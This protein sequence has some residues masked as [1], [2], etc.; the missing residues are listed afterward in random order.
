[1]R[2]ALPLALVALA[3]PAAAAPCEVELVRV[4][5]SARPIIEEWVAAE[6]SC[7]TRLEVRVIETEGGLYVVAT[8]AAGRIRERL[9]SDATT[10]AVLIASWAADAGAP[11]PAPPPARP[12]AAPTG[13]EPIT[14]QEPTISS[15]L[16]V[17]TRTSGR[18]AQTLALGVIM[19][20]HAGTGVRVEMDLYRLWRA[21]KATFQWRVAGVMLGVTA[22]GFWVDAEHV[23]GTDSRVFAL[24]TLHARRERTE[25]RLSAGIGASMSRVVVNDPMDATRRVELQALAPCAEATYTS[26]LWIAGWGLR[27]GAL[28]SIH[29]SLGQADM[30]WKR[31]AEWRGTVAVVRGW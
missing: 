25:M 23:V 20:R 4:P 29:P 12:P 11:A 5:E 13:T 24:A 9:V 10:A 19:N 3:A 17:P 14:I 21:D 30:T 18:R 1:M 16:V 7:A 22:T 15:T 31:G 28:L 8:D 6:P 26:T 27:G 2:I